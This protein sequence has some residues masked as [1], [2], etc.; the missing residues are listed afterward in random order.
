[1]RATAACVLAISLALAAAAASQTLPPS[2]KNSPVPMPSGTSIGCA[3]NPNALGITRIVEID[4]TAGP[5]FG[6]EHFKDHD[7]LR[8]KEV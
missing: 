4:T 8:P 1:M 2:A 5:G 6:F 3:N 7:F